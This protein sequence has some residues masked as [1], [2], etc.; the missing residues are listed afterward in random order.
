MSKAIQNQIDSLRRQVAEAYKR[1]QFEEGA[2]L[3][4][5]AYELT[6]QLYGEHHLNTAVAM[7]DMAGMYAA[8]GNVAAAEP[9]FYKALELYRAALGDKH[10]HVATSLHNLGILHHSTGSYTKAVSLYLQADEILRATVNEQHPNYIDNLSKLLSSYLAVHNYAGALT[11]ARKLLDIKRRHVG[12][13]HVETLGYLETV[14]QL[15]ARLGDHERAEPLYGQLLDAYRSAHGEESQ[16]VGHVLNSLAV[17]N[18]STGN[19][20]RAESLYTR[21][22]DILLRGVGENDPRFA[23]SLLNLSL[24]YKDMRSYKQ[25]EALALRALELIRRNEGEDSLALM[26]GL[27]ILALLRS[28]GGRHDEAKSLWRQALEIGRKHL[29]QNHPSVADMLNN[30]ATACYARG[31]NGEAELLFHEAMDIY[32]AA[33]GPRHPHVAG[34][35]HNLSTLYEAMGEY[36]KAVSTAEQALDIYRGVY[37]ERHPH[38]A[39]CLEG[40]APLRVMM[41]EQAEAM[42]LL[43]RANEIYDQLIGEI[44]SIGSERQRLSYL[45]GVYQSFDF[46][47]SVVLQHYPDSPTALQSAFD[48]TL[49]RKGVVVEAMAAQRRT[50]AAARDPALKSKFDELVVL[51]AQL[52]QK[53]FAGPGPEGV[54]AHTELLSQWENR[55]ETLEAEIARLLPQESLRKQLLSADGRRLARALP[56]DSALVEFVKFRLYKFRGAQ[57]AGGQPR[58]SERY[59]AFVLPSGDYESVRMVDLGSAEAVERMVKEF[60]ASFAGGGRELVLEEEPQ[61]EADDGAELRLTVFDPLAGALGGRTRL[62]IAPDGDLALV[63]FEALPTAD[64]RRLIDVYR[65]SYLGA[66]R[67]ALLFDATFEGR[68]TAPLVI[69][70]PD[71]NFNDAPP[72]AAPAREDWRRSWDLR[73]SGEFTR[74][75]GTRVEGETIA[76]RLKVV[77]LLGRA[78]VESQLRACRSPYIL[79]IATHGFFLANQSQQPDGKKYDPS[80]AATMITAW[81]LRLWS[82]ENPLLRS[83]L[84]LAGANAWLQGVPLPAEAEDGFLTAEDVSG[85]ELQATALVVLSACET[86]VGEVQTGEGVFGLR[87]AFVL[88]GART[89]IMS[90][91]KVP[92]EQTQELMT[93]FYRHL[94]MGQPR[95]EALRNAQLAIKEKYPAPF[96]WG[97]FI[98]QGDPR[99]LTEARLV[100]AAPGRDH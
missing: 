36:A 70:D 95:A 61:A 87:R 42:I 11:T 47:L 53:T 10:L 78:A 19:Y 60:R 59:V 8:A 68:P 14:A 82:T 17:L 94:L 6:R 12:E 76:D 3:A 100:I 84:V 99:P 74:L 51:R 89:L 73:G 4:E 72:A 39:V 63:P 32:R 77:P 49:R 33:L 27:N 48:L 45:R 66:G 9:L 38:I 85:L 81:P 46:T 44:F 2:R 91:W 35:M 75:P 34:S 28:D 86:G 97:A 31:E 69:A 7:N 30:F 56:T 22:A 96:Y 15:Y 23:T 55:V 20:A 90:L 57:A 64:G 24:L 83:G 37:G 21:S 18:Y 54:Q 5:R 26:W 50:P 29:P 58:F 93:S 41:N 25:A 62:L 80:S 98:C 40:L 1:E 67:D 16:E 65:V 71:F 79:H 52:A 88:A 43:R 92:D 13:R